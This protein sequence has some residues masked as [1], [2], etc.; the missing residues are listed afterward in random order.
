MFKSS[1]ENQ[2]Y[3]N[4]K[5]MLIFSAIF[6]MLACLFI[7]RAALSISLI[8]FVALTCVHKNILEQAKAFITNKFLVAL[9]FL[10]I[11][12]LISG[13]WSSNKTE[14]LH[15]LQVKLPF[16]LLPFSFSGKWKMNNHHWNIIGSFF[17]ALTFAAC[18]I[19][20]LFYLQNMQEVHAAYLKAK[21][22]PTSFDNDHVRFSLAIAIAFFV[23]LFK[24]QKNI[25]RKENFILAS[26]AL[27]FFVYLHLLSA[28][29]GLVAAYFIFIAFSIKL[30]L[31]KTRRLFLLPA[32]LI[33]PALSFFVFPTFQNR[34]KFLVYDFSYYK[35]NHYLPGATDGNRIL[36]IKAGSDILLKNPFGVGAGDI[37]DETIEWYFE[38]IPDILP[39]DQLYP[40]SEWLM[41]GTMMGWLGI[42][43]FSIILF[44]PLFIKMN[45]F[46]FEW[47]LLNLVLISSI[48]FDTGLGTQYGIF[49]HLISLLLWWK[50]YSIEAKPS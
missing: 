23:C 47:I 35:S 8:F 1:I 44:Y 40:S 9:S 34:I 6:L 46:R 49:L 31:N 32:L 37:W 2:H 28:R 39:T 13:I 29:T 21:V 33:V 26:L 19:S 22:L 27:L 42:I 41:Y 48:V 24:L 45:R 18:C 12:P 38:N 7:S 25:S 17:I 4:K 30:L 5:D 11:I 15:I 43:G 20:T 14:W 50:N 16:I 10:F 36:S 3:N